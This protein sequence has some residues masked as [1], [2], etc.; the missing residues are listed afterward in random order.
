MATCKDCIYRVMCY[1]HEHYGYGY[2][3]NERPCEMFKNK[4]D[5]VEVKHGI[6]VINPDGYYP[7][8]NQ[9]G[10]EPRRPLGDYDNRTPRCPNCGAK[11]RKEWETNGAKEN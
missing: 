6:W 10:Y 2:E 11:M 9:C 3:Y 7:Y 1:K 4:A 5:F 8:C